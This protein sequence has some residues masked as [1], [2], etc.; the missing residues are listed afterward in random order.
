MATFK[1]DRTLTPP[2][3]AHVVDAIEDALRELDEE[4]LS[5]YV[6]QGVIDKLNSSLEILNGK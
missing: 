3:L 2:E 5:E 6:S 1:E 4:P